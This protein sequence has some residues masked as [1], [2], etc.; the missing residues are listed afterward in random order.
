MLRNVRG[1]GFSLAEAIVK[2]RE[3][4]GFYR[5]PEDLL[6]VPGIGENRMKNF[7]DQFSFVVN[8]ESL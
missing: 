6:R 3:K 1:I 2:V 5:R 7:S 4:R 8:L